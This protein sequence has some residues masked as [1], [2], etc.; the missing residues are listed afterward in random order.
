MLAIEM[1]L[2]DN[3]ISRAQAAS[4]IAQHI[5]HPQTLA[6]CI[7]ELDELDEITIENVLYILGY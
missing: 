3:V 5:D 6:E 4:I 7:S 1:G 2:L